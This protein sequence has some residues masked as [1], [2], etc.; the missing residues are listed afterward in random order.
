M[1]TLEIFQ[2]L[3]TTVQCG[4]KIPLRCTFDVDPQFCHRTALSL[5]QWKVYENDLEGIY[6][7]LYAR[8]RFNIS[9][10]WRGGMND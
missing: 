8:T 4:P 7:S 5:F 2:S 1:A 10:F 6:S 9:F 3:P